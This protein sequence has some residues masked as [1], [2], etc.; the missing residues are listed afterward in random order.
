MAG[1]GLPPPPTRAAAGDFV[2]VAWY[3]DLNRALSQG[4]SIAWTVVNKAGSSIADL[5]NKN[6][7]LLTSIQGGIPGE[8]YHLTLPQYTIATQ[9]ASATQSGY[10][11]NTD[12]S[13][14][15]LGTGWSRNFMM[16]GG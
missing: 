10:L 1:G 6:H 14:F 4:G 16:M 5:Q 15:S 7:N 9:A 3:N 2:W 8:H 11:T 12:F 13:A